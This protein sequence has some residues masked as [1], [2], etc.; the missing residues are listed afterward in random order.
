[1]SPAVSVIVTAYNSAAWLRRAID[2]VRAQEF[3]DFEVIV[4][5]DGSTDNTGEICASYGS[6]IRY[7]RQE[8][9]GAGGARNTGIREA[10]GPYLAFLDADDE[11]LP[12]K[13]GDLVPLL[14]DA[15]DDIA[16]AGGLYLLRA[17]QGEW[18]HPVLE[19]LAIA[20]GGS[21]RIDF[22]ASTVRSG[23]S[24]IHTS[25]MILRRE[26]LDRLGL[27]R[28]DLCFSEDF[29]MWCRISGRYDWMLLGKPVSVYHWNPAHSHTLRIP[30]GL[31]GF[32]CFYSREEAGR[33]I[34]PR[35]IQAYRRL[36]MNL[37][38]PQFWDSVRFR[39]RDL[40]ADALRRLV[41]PGP[42]FRYA[43]MWWVARMPVWSWLP[44]ARARGF[45]VWLGWKACGAKKRAL[46]MLGLAGRHAAG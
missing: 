18:R 28:E 37:G 33:R 3:A 20:P 30:W 10:Q 29:E 45:M 13:L 44:L 40:V 9:R 1:M 15:P 16:G 36:C 35:R 5:D 34:E 4:V 42:S 43:V 41:P 25:S 21:G 11:Y 8:N 32:N 24:T 38:Y 14:R 7:I 19:R 31:R 27:F 6:A 17:H 12:N 23:T 2:S 39:R 46:R 22:L 26:I